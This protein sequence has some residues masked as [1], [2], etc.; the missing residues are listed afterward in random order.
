MQLYMNTITANYPAILAA[1]TA[2]TANTLC[3]TTIASQL[4]VS[5][6]HNVRISKSPPSARSSALLKVQQLQLVVR[7]VIVVLLEVRY[8]AR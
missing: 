7:V 8:C 6:Y 1:I 4:H 3:C 5:Y 2:A